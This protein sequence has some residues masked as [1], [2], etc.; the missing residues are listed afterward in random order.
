VRW[1]TSRLRV[2]LLAPAILTSPVAAAAGP[3]PLLPPL[4]RCLQPRLAAEDPPAEPPPAV[5]PPESAPPQLEERATAPPAE[6]APADESAQFASIGRLLQTRCAMPGCHLGPDAMAGLRLEAS[7]IYRSSVNV[8]ARTEPRLLRL[9]PGAPEQSLLYLKLLPPEEGHYRGP[10]MPFSMSPLTAEE[11]AL[12][13]AWIEAFPVDRWGAPPAAAETPA[14][15]PRT[16]HD[17]VL[18]NLPTSDPLGRRTVEFRIMHRFKEAT[19]EAGSYDFFGL[20]SGAW[21][22]IG[23]AYGLGETVEVGLRRTNLQHDYEAYS[24][25]VPVRQGEGRAPLSLALRGTFSDLRET[26]SFNRHRYGAQAI[27]ARRFGAHLSLML[28]PTYVT[29]TNYVDETDTR[30]TGAVGVGGEWRFNAK[31]AVTGEWIA[32]LSGVQN[33][34]Q[35]GS[36]GYSIATARHAFHIF[37]TNTSGS[38][39]DLYVTGG[40]I[41]LSDGDFRLG[42]NISRTFTPH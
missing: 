12:V 22:S 18:V 34:F 23:L 3:S 1:T 10:R 13:R 33:E 40:D 39:T 15:T 4:L 35:S 19:R 32:Q 28:V 37:A 30:G 38:H 2:L 17:G 31:M 27:L 21:I 8:R 29:S 26:L 16:F 5:E 36:V 7:Q 11:I 20:D 6:A 14:L 24:K 9:V 41:K 42:F 25:W